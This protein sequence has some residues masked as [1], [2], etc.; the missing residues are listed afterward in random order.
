VA[1]SAA[2]ANP[3]LSGPRTGC[4]RFNGGWLQPTVSKLPMATR[5]FFSM[6]PLRTARLIF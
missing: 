6:E 3:F 5:S 1:A 4:N 2:F